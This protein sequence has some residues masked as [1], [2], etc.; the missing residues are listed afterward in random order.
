MGRRVNHADGLAA[1]PLISRQ[2]ACH[3]AVECLD[4][5]VEDPARSIEMTGTQC[6]G[7]SG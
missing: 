5:G 1:M 2:C 3:A 4:R 6:I 7:V